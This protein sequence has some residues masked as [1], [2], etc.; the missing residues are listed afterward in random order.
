[1]NWALPLIDRFENALELIDLRTLS[2][3]DKDCIF[4]SV[5]KTGRV[6]LISEDNLTGSVSSDI[7]AMVGESCFEYLDAPVMRLGSIDTPIPFHKDLE[8]DYLPVKKIED[9]IK[10]LLRY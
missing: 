9:S 1:M 2:P 5:K 3:L 10:V 8:T 7:A 4:N 6:L